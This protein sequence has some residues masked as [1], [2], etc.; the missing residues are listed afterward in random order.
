MS[1]N[2]KEFTNKMITHIISGLNIMKM[3]FK[4]IAVTSALVLA[5]SVV[6]IGVAQAATFVLLTGQLDY[7]QTSTNVANLQ[8][9]LASSE[10]I[11]PQ[12]KVTGYFGPLTKSAV[13]NFQ[14]AYG[15]AQVGRVGPQTLAKINSL[16]L[17][18]IGLTGSWNG[19][20]TVYANST[21]APAIYSIAIGTTNTTVTVS[22]V[23][24]EN[25]IAQVYY[26]TTPFQM[27]EATSNF[28]KPVIMGGTTTPGTTSYQRSQIVAIGNL[29]PHTTYYYMIEATDTDGNLSYTWP[30]TFT[31]GY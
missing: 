15:I 20:G 22:W 6:T 23:T 14:N 13:M 10:S 28:A 8:N 29:Q 7:G 9:F 1:I 18:G 5:L 26:S 4:N 21:I 27:A 17:S 2:N 12:G 24:D 11:Y 25:T 16:I 19:G 30:T 31:T 3:N